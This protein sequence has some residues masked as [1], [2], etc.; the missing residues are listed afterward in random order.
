MSLVDIAERTAVEGPEY[1][2]EN[3]I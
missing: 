2:Q 1:C 3:D